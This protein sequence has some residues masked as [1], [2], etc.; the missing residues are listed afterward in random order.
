MVLMRAWMMQSNIHLAAEGPKFLFRCCT[1]S[2][3]F[4]ILV[5]VQ[6]SN[7]NNLLG[8]SCS[9]LSSDSIV[10]CEMRGHIGLAQP[11]SAAHYCPS[12]ARVQRGMRN[13]NFVQKVFI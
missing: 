7:F 1:G 9:H 11:G 3:G 8:P 12:M 6:I 2:D 5:F 13:R 4:H 10:V